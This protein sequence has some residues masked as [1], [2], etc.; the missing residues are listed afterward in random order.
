ME[1]RKIQ[2][3]IQIHGKRNERF[4]HDSRR[5]KEDQPCTIEK[6]KYKMY[7]FIYPVCS[8]SGVM[9]KHILINTKNM[10]YEFT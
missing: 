2:I 5:Q 9:S 7:A 6:F 1:I 10:K 3:V 8:L 4:I